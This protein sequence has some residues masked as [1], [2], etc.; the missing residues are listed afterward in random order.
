VHLKQAIFQYSE[1]VVITT[2]NTQA[3]VPAGRHVTIELTTGAGGVSIRP[4]GR[5]ID[6]GPAEWYRLQ[7]QGLV[8]P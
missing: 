1:C 3:T 4:P 8:K 2:A 6:V 7:Q 5:S